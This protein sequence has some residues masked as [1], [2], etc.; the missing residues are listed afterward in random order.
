MKKFIAMAAASALLLGSTA[1]QAG[2]AS[3][4]SLSNA[5]AKTSAVR[6]STVAKKKN[7]IV[8]GSPIFIIGVILGAVVALE[9]TGAINI[10]DD[11][12]SP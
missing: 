1:A 7:G 8:P 12:D 10:I 9:L 11:S 2:S 6:A 3:A 4:L 5:P